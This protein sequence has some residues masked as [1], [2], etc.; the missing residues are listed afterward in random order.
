MQ[1]TLLGS[2]TSYSGAISSGMQSLLWSA[3]LIPPVSGPD[4]W[5]ADSA[6]DIGNEPDNESKILFDS[7]DIWN[8]LSCDSLWEHQNPE[9]GA[10]N[11][12]YVRMRNRGCSDYTGSAS[13]QITL[14]WAKASTALGWPN[15]WTGKVN[16]KGTSIKMGGEIG[17]VTLTAAAGATIPAGQTGVTSFSWNPPNPQD[18]ASFGGDQNHFC[19]LARITGDGS[20]DKGETGNLASNV[21]KNKTIVWKNVEVTSVAPAPPPPERRL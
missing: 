2:V 16:V 6:A 20:P 7:D 13:K 1:G 9:Y 5:M 21:K 8:R 12:I 3:A 15:P 17:T 19:I 18:Y 4:I 11:C 14:Y 10:A